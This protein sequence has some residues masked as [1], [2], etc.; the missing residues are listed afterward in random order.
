MTTGNQKYLLQV[1]R[2]HQAHC[3]RPL[4]AQPASLPSGVDS[5]QGHVVWSGSLP[6]RRQAHTAPGG[7]HRSH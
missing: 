3:H 5:L 2:S 7:M 6:L 1:R 4:T